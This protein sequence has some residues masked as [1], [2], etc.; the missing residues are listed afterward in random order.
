MT[1]EK[2]I[3]INA[4]Q[5]KKTVHHSWLASKH[6]TSLPSLYQIYGY[7]G[8]R[9]HQRSKPGCHVQ[10]AY[11]LCVIC[12]QCS[13]EMHRHIVWIE[14]QQVKCAIDNPTDDCR[15]AGHVA[16][17]ILLCILCVVVYGVCNKTQ[18]E[19]RPEGAELCCPCLIR[20]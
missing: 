7:R 4:Q 10:P 13:A 9:F 19:S 1:L 5:Q 18:D 12:R 11:D 15:G 6:S 17:F 2:G 3:K 20:S 16:H 8:R 14:P